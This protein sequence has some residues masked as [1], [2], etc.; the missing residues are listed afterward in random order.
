M[1]VLG[2]VATMVAL[3]LPRLGGQNNQMRQAVRRLSGITRELQT[4]A[5]LQGTI[6]RLVIDLGDES[7]KS[8]QVYWVEKSS[9]RTVLT[10]DEMAGDELREKALLEMSSDER[11]EAPPPLFSKDAKLSKGAGE[12][13]GSLRFEDVE[14]KR[15]EKPIVTGKAYIHFFPQGLADEAVIH[16]SGGDKLKWSLIVH[17][18]TGKTEIMTEHVSLKELSE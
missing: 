2:I 3:V 4:S 7:K 6:Y 9:G 12:L 18:L 15:S 17:P 10:P 11:A 5:K 8:T 13:P 1:V 14:L 16:L